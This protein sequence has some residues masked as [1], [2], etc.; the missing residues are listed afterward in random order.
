ME[1]TPAAE[2]ADEETSRGGPRAPATLGVAGCLS[3]VSGEVRLPPSLHVLD[4]RLYAS[5]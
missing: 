5:F 2:A 4:R 1:I 3:S